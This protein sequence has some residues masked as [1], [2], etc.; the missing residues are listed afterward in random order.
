MAQTVG[1]LFEAT[2]KTRRRQ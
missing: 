2:E 1:K